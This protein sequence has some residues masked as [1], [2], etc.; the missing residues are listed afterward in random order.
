MS[1]QARHQRK[2]QVEEQARRDRLRITELE[3]PRHCRVCR[4]T[5]EAN[6]FSKYSRSGRTYRHHQCTRCRSQSYLKSELCQEKRAL[7]DVL[8]TGPCQDCGHTHPFYQNQFVCVRGCPDFKLGYYWTGRSKKAILEEVKK[9]AVVCSNCKAT[10]DYNLFIHRAPRGSLLA[11][12]PP[13][14]KELAGLP[15]E[16][17]DKS[18]QSTTCTGV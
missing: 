17:D 14:L 4:K 11:Q 7:L 5:K 3:E 16:P 12:L 9:Y 13:E 2:N 18:S 6:Q 10:R 8:R 1:Q 15:V